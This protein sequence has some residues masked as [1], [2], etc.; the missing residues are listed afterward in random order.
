MSVAIV[1]NGVNCYAV[2]KYNGVSKQNVEHLTG[3]V[4]NSPS[5]TLYYTFEN[6]SGTT[7]TDRSV[8]TTA[9]NGTFASGAQ[10]PEWDDHGPKKGSYSFFSEAASGDD[11]HATI[12]DHADLDFD[13]N[14][15]WSFSAW[16]KADGAGYLSILSK[17]DTAGNDY[18][19]WYIGT[20]AGK[21][22]VYLVSDWDTNDQKI[23]MKG[24]TSSPYNTLAGGS[25]VHV[26]VT[27]SGNGA[28]SG[29]KSYVNNSLDTG[30]AAHDSNHDAVSGS[31][32]NN[33]DAHLGNDSATG[34]LAFG[35]VDELA[36][37]KGTVLTSTQVAK[38]YNSGGT[39]PSI[40]RGL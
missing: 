6:G 39:P 14:T 34:G 12:S 28:A 5:P 13:H 10:A 32:T 29:F 1:K 7:I 31:C 2:S 9:H 21:L 4:E 20:H 25:W 3:S 11:E 38:L 23:W 17:R 36:L 27:Y 26:V 33:L 19:G 24:S 35:D 30:F 16:V 37:W 18:T 15:A 40:V 22:D 8:G